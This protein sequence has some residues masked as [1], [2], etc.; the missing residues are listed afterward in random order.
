M[1]KK[2]VVVKP[3]T[4]PGRHVP[5]HHVA[6]HYKMV[7]GGK[8]VTGNK[9]VRRHQSIKYTNK[10]PQDEYEY[11]RLE[12]DLKDMM[13][14]AE[15]ERRSPKKRILGAFA[16]KPIKKVSF[17]GLTADSRKL[18]KREKA[19]KLDLREIKD[20]LEENKNIKYH[21]K[22]DKEYKEAIMIRRG[23]KKLF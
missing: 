1:Q 5:A 21:H 7:K 15:E 16:K 14:D 23:R 19:V 9:I 8:R 22:G 6:G 13:R 3:Y 12:D 18:Q 17:G 10:Y 2:R 11:E 20:R 4:V